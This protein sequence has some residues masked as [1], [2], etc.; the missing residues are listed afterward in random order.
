MK[1][2]RSTRLTGIRTHVMRNGE[3]REGAV[4][5]HKTLNWLE[6]YLVPVC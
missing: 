4:D 2:S 1:A 6:H 3:N 5:I